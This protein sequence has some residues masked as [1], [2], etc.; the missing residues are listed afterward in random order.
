MAKRT[1]RRVTIDTRGDKIRTKQSAKNECDIN[2][3]LAKYLRTGVV[4]P[5][6]LSKRQA[7][8]AD[9]SEVGDYHASLNKVIEAKDAFMTLPAKIRSRFQNDPGQL[10]DFVADSNNRDEAI[11]LGII[12]KIEEETPTEP[13]PDPPPTPPET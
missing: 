9:V 7:A 1:P 2:Q 11:E 3:I 13:D 8:F 4:S 6:N 5:E 10:L 12:T